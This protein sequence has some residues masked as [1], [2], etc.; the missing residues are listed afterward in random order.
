M[1]WLSEIGAQD[2]RVNEFAVFEALPASPRCLRG[3][4]H[5]DAKSVPIQAVIYFRGDPRTMLKGKE[6]LY[7]ALVRGDK[8]G[9]GYAAVHWSVSSEGSV[10]GHQAAVGWAELEVDGGRVVIF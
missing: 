7:F 8:S 1:F 5:C 3:P 10:G 6:N 4:S 9:F 2:T